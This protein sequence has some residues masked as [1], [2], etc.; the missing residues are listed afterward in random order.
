MKNICFGRYENYLSTIIDCIV[1]D[2]LVYLTTNAK[3]I[4]L[5][6]NFFVIQEGFNIF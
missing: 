6:S 4:R 5:K 1:L 2:R 3:Y